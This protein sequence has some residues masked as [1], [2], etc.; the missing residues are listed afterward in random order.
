MKWE[1]YSEGK[2]FKDYAEPEWFK[3]VLKRQRRENL[4][5]LCLLLPTVY[6]VVKAIG[7]YVA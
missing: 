3:R 2:S 1:N 7:V 5:N 4:F 6:L